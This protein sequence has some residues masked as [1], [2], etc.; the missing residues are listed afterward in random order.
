MNG[1]RKVKVVYKNLMDRLNRNPVGAPETPEFFEILETLYSEEHARVASLMPLKPT[2][3]EKLSERTGV[4]KERLRGMLGEMAG[5]GLV[6][7][8]NNPKNDRTYYIL[9]PPIVGFFEFSLMRERDDFDQ[10]RLAELMS[11][12]LH[13]K[14]GKFI[15]EVFQEST[16]IGRAVV[17]ETALKPEALSSILDIDSVSDYIENSRRRSVALCY[18]RH[19]QKLIGKPCEKPMEICFALDNGSDYLVGNGLARDVSKEEMKDLLEVARGNGLVQVADNVKRGVTFI[20]N[21]CGCCCGM[22]VAI[23]E[24]GLKY[25]VHT[26]AYIA[27]ISAPQCTGC[28]KC[29]KI[30]PVKAITMIERP[31]DAASSPDGKKRKRLAVVDES[32]CLGCGVCHRACSAE[33]IELKKRDK[34]TLTPESTLERIFNMAVERGKMHHLIFDEVEGPPLQFMKSL[35]GAF[36]ALPVSKQILLNKE[37]KS[38]FLDFITG[39][40]KI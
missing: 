20:C 40:A 13:E 32:V 1:D 16:Q 28:G 22:M 34:R 3:L 29:E 4:E 23:N 11:H 7:D 14:S 15:K 17:H 5:R 37:I 36:L 25:A 39:S 12:F 8:Y 31:A 33:A 26:S 6:V 10:K 2:P 27:A 19:K 30:C 24:H 21:C 9:N 18:C 35:A 38:R